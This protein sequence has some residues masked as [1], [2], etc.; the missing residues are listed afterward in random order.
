LAI[1][2]ELLGSNA[3]FA[4]AF[5]QYAVYRP[6][7]GM[8]W[9]N[10]VRL[11]LAKAFSG[12]FV[13]TSQSF[14]SGGGT[15][16]RGFP[17]NGAGPQRAVQFCGNLATHT[18]CAF[19]SVPVGGNQLFVLNSELRF[20]LRFLENLGG[21]VFYDGGNIDRSINFNEFLNNYTSTLGIGLRYHTPVGPLRL[22]LGHN[23][24]PTPGVG[25]T[26]YFIT[27]GQAF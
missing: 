5:G 21:V 18:N 26:Q 2:P 6:F 14:F 1:T 15:T 27:L 10:S 9:A 20:P 11:G 22:D 13:P 4:K 16:L 23:L 3:S 12:S 17:L 25:S 8:V 7:H 19:I 24:N